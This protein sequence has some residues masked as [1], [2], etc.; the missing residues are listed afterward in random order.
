MAPFQ[1]LDQLH[2][3]IAVTLAEIKESAADPSRS[4]IGYLMSETYFKAEYDP[5]ISW[6]LQHAGMDLIAAMKCFQLFQD[7]P[8]TKR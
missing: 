4:A 8:Y 7:N 1:L 2:Q 5:M 6:D 3:H